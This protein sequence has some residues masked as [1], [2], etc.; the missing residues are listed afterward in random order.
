MAL[1]GVGENSLLSNSAF[2]A[3]RNKILEMDR[4]GKYLPFCTRMVFLKY[5]TKSG[6]TDLHF[7]GA[8]DRK[9]YI[10]AMNRVLEPYLAGNEI[11]VE[12]E[13]A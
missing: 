13:E 4:E 7:W 5:Y 1:L 9:A 12:K 10:A 3:K 2:D 8:E 11:V 6:A